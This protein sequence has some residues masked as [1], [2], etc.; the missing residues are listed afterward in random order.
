MR[1]IRPIPYALV[2]LFCAFLTTGS[3]APSYLEYTN[4]GLLVQADTVYHSPTFKKAVTAFQ[5]ANFTEAVSLFNEIASDESQDRIIRRDAWH[6]LC[7][8][9]L[10]MRND[11]EARDALEQMAA[12]EP[13]RV[14]LD[15]DVEPPHLLRLY[16]SVYKERDGVYAV[17]NTG[18][19]YTIAVVDFTNQS[20]D[21]RERLEPLSKGFASLFINQLSGATE[22]KILERERI[23]WLLDELDLQANT[24]RVDPQTAVQAGKLLGVHMVLMGS[25]MKFG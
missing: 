12:Y 24:S 20:I 2:G 3:S 9:Y 25:F 18:Q 13:P 8:I 4:A 22:L 15:P 11:G 19:K 6:Y 21:D 17:E 7:R 5:E 14:E 10:A 1:L 23:Q 16:Y